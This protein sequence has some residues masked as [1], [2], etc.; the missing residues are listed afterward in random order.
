LWVLELNPRLSAT[1]HLYPN[2]L[3]V[4]IK[5]CSGDLNDFQQHIHH[6]SA[7]QILYADDAL[8][9]SSNFAWPN[10]VADIPGIEASESNVIIERNAPICTVMAEAENAE[11]AHMLIL[12]RAEILREILLK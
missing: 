5:A 3:P 1:F 8:K 6:S 11:T 7:Q 12:Q 10:W 2:L 4:H 9:I